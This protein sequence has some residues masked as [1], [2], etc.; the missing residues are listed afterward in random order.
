MAISRRSAKMRLREPFRWATGTPGFQSKPR[1]TAMTSAIRHL[2]PG[3]LAADDRSA[4]LETLLRFP[5]PGAIV[6]RLVAPGEPEL[7][8]EALHGKLRICEQF[9]AGARSEQV[10]LAVQAPRIRQLA[11]E[12][13]SRL[14]KQVL[15]VRAILLVPVNVDEVVTFGDPACGKEPAGSLTV[16]FRRC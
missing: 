9:L 11:V 15:R 10:T 2:F 6:T 5:S 16:C 8:M 14:S 4:L 1:P 13:L 7:D 3:V 12:R